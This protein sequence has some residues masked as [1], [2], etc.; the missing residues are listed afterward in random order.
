MH[1]LLLME[2]QIILIILKKPTNYQIVLKQFTKMSRLTDT[3]N[4]LRHFHSMCSAAFCCLEVHTFTP[5]QG[6]SEGQST[7]F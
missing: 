1:K 4:Y 3:V 7:R 5:L 6:M 2:K